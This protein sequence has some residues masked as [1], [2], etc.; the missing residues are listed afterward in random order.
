MNATTPQPQADLSKVQTLLAR[1]YTQ[2]ALRQRFFEDPELVGKEFG[3]SAQEIQLLS[4]LPPA[5]THFFSHSLIHKRQGQV[6]KLLAYS[7][8]VMGSTFQKLFHQFAEETNFK[9]IRKHQED[10]LA[11]AS[12]LQQSL[13]Q[14]TALAARFP[15][16]L[17][18]LLAYEA[19]C[20][21]ANQP[22]C[23]LLVRWFRYPVRDIARALF[24][25]Q[26]PPETTRMTLAVWLRPTSSH[27]LTHRLF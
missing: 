16:W 9:G 4:T 19:A 11:F 17:G 18:D 25:E 20:I 15:A 7:Y 6:Q 24:K 26:P 21:E 3:L 22:S 2:T 13:K 12:Y 5:Q 14:D 1:L 23:R 8:G 27:E 10:A